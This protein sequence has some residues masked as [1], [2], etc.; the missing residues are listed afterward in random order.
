MI[1]F[2]AAGIIK[3]VKALAL[4][5]GATVVVRICRGRQPAIRAE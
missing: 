3:Y 2:T 4:H 5:N 1:A